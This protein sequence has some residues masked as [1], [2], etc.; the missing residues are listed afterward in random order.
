MDG[1]T[2]SSAHHAARAFLAVLAKLQRQVAQ[3][4][5]AALDGHRF[6]VGESVLLG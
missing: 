2:T 5:G 4:L 3:G 6:V 1:D